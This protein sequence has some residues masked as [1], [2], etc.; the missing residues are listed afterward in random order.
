[1]PK[2][3]PFTGTFLAVKLLDIGLV[4][5]YFFALGLLSA[6][7]ID[8]VLGEFDKENYKTISLWKLGLEI[9]AQL[10]FVGILAYGLRNIVGLIPF[11]LD[12]VGGFQHNLLKELDGGEVLAVVLIIFQKNLVNKVLYFV[13]QVLNIKQSA[14]EK[15][16]GAFKAT[17]N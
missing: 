7:I 5:V 13:E 14:E 12:G 6:K 4:T 2:K 3:V 10:I 8:G 17:K 11:P 9:I 1:M 16:K 15:I